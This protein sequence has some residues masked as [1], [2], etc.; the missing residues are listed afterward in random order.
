M[1][2]IKYRMIEVCMRRNVIDENIFNSKLLRMWENNL[3]KLM[4][5]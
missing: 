4:W 3:I 2:V 1:N 5:L